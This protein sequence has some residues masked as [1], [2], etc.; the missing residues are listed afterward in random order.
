[1]KKTVE[2]IIEAQEYKTLIVSIGVDPFNYL[3][4]SRDGF[5]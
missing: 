5:I 2:R 1:M 3:I 4:A